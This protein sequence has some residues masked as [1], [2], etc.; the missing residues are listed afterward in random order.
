MSKKCHI[1]IS[2]MHF[3]PENFRINDIAREW[4]MRGYKVSVLTGY[5]N[6][7]EGRLFDGYKLKLF[8]EEMYNGITIHRIPIV[9]RGGNIV[10]LLLNYVSFI[11]SGLAWS[12]FTK[13]KPDRIFIFAT[14]P[15]M[16]AVPPIFLAKLKK[17][18]CFIYVQDLW[19]DNLEAVFKVRS[20]LI[21]KPIE[22]IAKSIYYLSDTVLVPSP[23]FSEAIASLGV[24]KSKIVYWP[25]HAEEYH[26]QR[27]E[28]VKKSSRFS[29]VY[30]GNIGQA[31]GLSKL[32]LVAKILAAKNVSADLISFTILGDGRYRRNLEKEIQESG[33][34]SYFHFKGRVKSEEVPSLLQEHDFAFLSLE[35]SVIFNKTIPAKVQTYLASG[36]P[37]IASAAGEVARIIQEAQCGYCVSPEDTEELTSLIIEASQNGTKTLETF[38]KNAKRYCIAN[39]N[40]KVLFDQMDELLKS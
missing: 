32:I 37:L 15:V 1:L 18:P 26:F 17:I 3:Y 10:S 25:Q 21:L 29:I 24:S 14:S 8:S 11:F 20:N 4:I 22:S 35:N 13:V 33:T 40:Q 2:S 16:Q 5:P 30:A 38:R 36:M 7:P 34:Q 6:Y 19:P 31:Q 27:S 23:S 12:L 28:F 39:F 9:L